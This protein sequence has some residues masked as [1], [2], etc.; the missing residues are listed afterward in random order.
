M[1]E[2]TVYP[3]FGTIVLELCPPLIFYFV[4]TSISKQSLHQSLSSSLPPVDYGNPSTNSNT[5]ATHNHQEHPM[6]NSHNSSSSSN[7]RNSMV[8]H[9]QPHQGYVASNGGVL[10]SGGSSASSRQP[11]G[12]QSSLSAAAGSHASQSGQLSWANHQLQRE[13]NFDLC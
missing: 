13:D 9:H 7:L 12:G 8:A 1:G 4:Q 11:Q 2:R 6:G 5:S 10:V 3:Y